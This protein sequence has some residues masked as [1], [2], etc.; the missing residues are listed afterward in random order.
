MQTCKKMPYWRMVYSIGETR[1]QTLRSQ[2][3]SRL[4]R[5]GLPEMPIRHNVG[6]SKN[7]TNVPWLKADSLA[8]SWLWRLLV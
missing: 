7:D 4:R 1:R 5:Y 2:G 3:R 6:T 8:S